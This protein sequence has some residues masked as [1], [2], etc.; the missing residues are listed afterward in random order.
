VVD[1]TKTGARTRREASALVP[2]STPGDVEIYTPKDGVPQ[3]R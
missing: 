2:G 3:W 1:G